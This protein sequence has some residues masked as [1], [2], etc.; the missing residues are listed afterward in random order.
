MDLIR[1]CYRTKMRL[2]DGSDP[3]SVT[4]MF[5][6]KNADFIGVPTPFGSA[7]WNL[8]EELR[9]DA[10]L[11]EQSGTRPWSNG[12]RDAGLVGKRLCFP[13]DYFRNGT[14]AGEVIEKSLDRAGIPL[15]C[16]TEEDQAGGVWVSGEGEVNPACDC[17][18]D[19]PDVLQVRF[20]NVGGCGVIAN[21]TTATR[22]PASCTWAGVIPANLG[23]ANFT[24]S[25]FGTTWQF[26]IDCFLGPE[27][28]QLSGDACPPLDIT[29][30]VTDTMACCSFSGVDVYTVRFFT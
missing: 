19:L 8:G 10:Y 27:T 30:T 24:L 5:A 21:F 26:S 23:D 7:N 11:G 29:F 28:V 16:E 3:V 17:L 25:F 1:S 20:S 15:C 14:P 2:Q 13:V 12:Q 6:D 18:L 4:W 22:I 9:F